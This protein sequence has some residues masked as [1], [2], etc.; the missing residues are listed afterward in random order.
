MFLNRLKQVIYDIN[1]L[2]VRQ[3]DPFE[4]MKNVL[5][6]S[7]P[8]HRKHKTLSLCTLR[9]SLRQTS[10]AIG[11]IALPNWDQCGSLCTIYIWKQHCI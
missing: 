3:T 1:A 5:T 10:Y 8:L 11:A 6:W 4:I 7:N 2:A 9:G